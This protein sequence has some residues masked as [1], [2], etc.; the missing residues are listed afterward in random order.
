[1]KGIIRTYL[2][3]H[4]TESNVKEYCYKEL[5]EILMVSSDGGEHVF[6]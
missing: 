2:R 1:M 3:N 6:R 4:P 5:C